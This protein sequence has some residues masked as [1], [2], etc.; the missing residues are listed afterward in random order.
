MYEYCIKNG[1]EGLLRQWDAGLNGGITPDGLSYGTNRCV[2]W[3]CEKGH[4]WRASVKSR[5]A[6]SGCPVCAGKKVLPGDND[7]SATNPGLSA[8]WH[9]TK[10]GELRPENVVAGTHRKVWWLCGKGHEW[11]AGVASRVRGAGCPV[12]AGKAVVPGENDLE[13]FHPD[14]A[15]EW[16]TVK[17]G[18]LNPRMVTPYSNRRVWWRC[19]LGH[20]YQAAIGARTQGSGC[21]YCA[22]RKVFP[23]FN[24]L[25]S[26]EPEAAAQWHPLLNGK[27][28]PQMVTSRSHKKVWWRCKEGHVWSAAIYS[29]TGPMHCGC[30]V[31]AGKVKIRRPEAYAAMCRPSSIKQ[32]DKIP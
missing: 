21:P 32:S 28:T 30:P 22:G 10:N 23:G 9:P 19:R 6:G 3:R 12:C 18:A 16:H 13:S 8:Q 25:A 24:D 7:L 26:L 11:K 29:R 17:N 31:C 14:I 5:C 27:L 15:V 2:W 4:Q 1:L 20:E